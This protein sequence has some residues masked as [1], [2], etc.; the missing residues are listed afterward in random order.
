LRRGIYFILKY[1]PLLDKKAGH[2]Q[3]TQKDISDSKLGFDFG[4]HCAIR[5]ETCLS[6]RFEA[7]YNLS[8]L[9]EVMRQGFQKVV[10]TKP[11]RDFF[12]SSGAFVFGG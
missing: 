12:T 1:L 5:K 8:L 7:I 6:Q 2:H 3:T 10:E 4:Y 9:E 11:P